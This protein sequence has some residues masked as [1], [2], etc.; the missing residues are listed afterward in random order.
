MS[1]EEHSSG[2]VTVDDVRAL[3][4]ASTPHFALQLR[5]RIRHLIAGL[6][7]GHPA[8]VAGEAEMVRLETLGFAGEQR[9]H[10]AEPGITPLRSVDDSASR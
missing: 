2:H 1:H 6:P 5:A 7:E 10:R 3:S 4:G 9:G 8:R